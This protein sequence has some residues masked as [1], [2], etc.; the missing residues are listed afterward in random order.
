MAA[1]VLRISF[2]SGKGSTRPAEVLRFGDIAIDLAAREIRAGRRLSRIEP[3]AA[4]VLSVLIAGA[5]RVV[6]RQA[7]LETCWPSSAGSDEAL[8]QAVAQ[9]RRALA[10]RPGA[11]ACIATV[12]KSGYRWTAQAP[13][14]LS[15]TSTNRTRAWP[16]AA[17]LAA[18]T[19]LGCGVTA[20]G[21]SAS[22]PPRPALQSQRVR[23]VA[24]PGQA[25]P[26]LPPLPPLPS[27]Q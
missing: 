10:V 19:L 18:T 2:G 17:G 21:V 27:P 23:I 8:T 7:L 3:R 4:A 12:P 16:L 9:L 22:H 26:P 6:T 1:N 24:Q 25:L 11:P 20:I 13:S 15:S 14:S 5:G